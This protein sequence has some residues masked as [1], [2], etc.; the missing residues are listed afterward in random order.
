[1]DVHL[2]LEALRPWVQT[3]PVRDFAGEVRVRVLGKTPG[4][5]PN[6]LQ[7]LRQQLG[8]LDPDDGFR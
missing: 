6:L 5:I 1:M 3:K 7:L 8:V 2:V 4:E